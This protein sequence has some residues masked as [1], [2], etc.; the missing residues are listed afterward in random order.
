MIS[1]SFDKTWTQNGSIKQ[2]K[3]TNIYSQLSNLKSA[4][5]MELK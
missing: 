2:V 3:C 5:K 4:I 1:F